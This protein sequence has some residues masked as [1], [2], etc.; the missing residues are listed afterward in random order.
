MPR[1]KPWLVFQ[2][3]KFKAPVGLERLQLEQF[4]RFIEASLPSDLLPYRDIGF[5]I[6]G[7]VGRGLVNY[8]AGHFRRLRRRHQ[9]RQQQRAGLQSNRALHLRGPPV[10][11]A[12]SE[13]GRRMP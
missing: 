9:H 2:F 4:A 7:N 1:A 3:G 5:K 11:R 13:G 12:L 10:F 6:G 8:D